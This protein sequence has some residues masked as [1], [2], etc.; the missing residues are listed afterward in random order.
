MRALGQHNFCGE[1]YMSGGNPHIDA[2][3][4]LI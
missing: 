2:A 4:R 3:L 1:C